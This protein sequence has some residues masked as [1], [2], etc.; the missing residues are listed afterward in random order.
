MAA[1]Q[2]SPPFGGDST[3]SCEGYTARAIVKM[4]P[5][6]DPFPAGLR[7][8][9][10]DDDPICLLI[11]EKM[12]RRCSYEV[13][14]CGEAIIALDMLRQNRS[15]FDLV[16][17]DVYMPDMD[18]F[19]LLELVGLEMDL[20]VIMMSTDGGTSAV[21]KGI[22]HG[23]CDYLLKPVR[24]EEL[25]NIWQ[26]VVRKRRNEVKDVEHSGSVDDNDRIKRLVEDKEHP[27]CSTSK[28]RKDVKEE[29][30]DNDH[31][32]DD[33]TALKKPRVVWS[34]ELHQQFVSAVNQ[35]GID[36]AVPKRI[37]ELMG[38]QGLTRENVASHLQKY[39]LYLKRLSM[40]PHHNAV[41]LPFAAGSHESSIINPLSSL[42][43]INDLRSLAT[44]GQLSPQ[45][46]ASVHS[47]ILNRLGS[48]NGLGPGALDNSGWL[49]LAALQGSNYGSLGRARLQTQWPNSQGNIT[50]ALS[51][52]VELDQL[53][54]TQQMAA[55]CQS[56]PIDDLAGKTSLQHQ[57]GGM[58]NT[59]NSV[60]SGFSS[61]N[62][63]ALMMHLL[64]KQQQHA[65]NKP[66]GGV[67]FP[68]GAFSGQNVLLGETNH[69]VV[70]LPKT[71]SMTSCFNSQLINSGLSSSKMIPSG[72]IGGRGPPVSLELDNLVSNSGV[73]SA[74]HSLLG[75]ADA[76]YQTANGTDANSLAAP[77]SLTAAEEGSGTHLVNIDAN[78]NPQAVRGSMLNFSALGNLSC[79][80]GPGSSQSKSMGW[81]GQNASAVPG[82][83]QPPPP[84]ESSVYSQILNANPNKSCVFRKTQGDCF[85][86]SG[87]G[88]D[89]SWNAGGSS[90]RPSF[91]SA[92]TKSEQ[93]T[94]DG[95]HI[96][97]EEWISDS[98]STKLESVVP[99]LGD[100]S[101]DDLMALILKQEI[102]GFTET[103]IL[104]DGFAPEICL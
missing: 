39:R 80:I 82:V 44:S 53:A 49:Q 7:V 19:K 93:S 32:T 73:D 16:I 41:N 70:Q 11:L 34:V 59:A 20:P 78:H 61:P 68:V 48:I 74:T 72:C 91:K 25:K 46:L 5:T 6:K 94:T 42:D 17:S 100:S 8:L 52:G 37:L 54:Q 24:I 79:R 75:L 90:S 85:E 88:L 26:H 31:E 18:G 29:D 86:L 65:H 77:A 13:T 92:C 87:T 10:V 56:G 55:R 40:A 38:K 12:L 83:I 96:P 71:D 45:A 47:G 63:T 98:A 23:A 89:F 67:D 9:V 60:S 14:T 103:D 3:L 50:Q 81:Q 69:C 66:V 99:N 43:G 97:K 33:P 36:K 15:R 1:I 102:T 28:K 104:L 30:D 101:S 22:T 58:G 21:M 51:G 35:L 76:D 2:Q 64:Q 4:E 57:L 27:C 84:F 62:G 95:S